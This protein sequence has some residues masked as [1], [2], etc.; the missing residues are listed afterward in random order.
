MNS[1][2]PSSSDHPIT[3]SPD[4]PTLADCHL[5]FE[6]SLPFSAVARLACRRGHPFA[7]REAFEKSRAAVADSTTFLDLYAEICRLFREPEDFLDASKALADSL[8][9]WGLAYAEVYVSPEIFER[10]GLD[11][12]V[13]LEA[14]C[15]GLS[16]ATPGGTVCRVLLDAVRQWGPES[17]GRVLDL[18]ERVRPLAV[19]GFGLGGD[20]TSQPASAF[21]GVYARAR[22]LGLKT[23]VHAGEWAGP[24]SLRGALD[25]LRPDRVDH[26]IAAASDRSLLERLAGERTF[27]CV[28][29][30]GNLIT[31]AVARWED[32]PLPRLLEAGVPVALSADDP[33][34]FA[35]DTSREYAVA[36]DRLGL[37]PA[38]LKSCAENAWRAAFCS[39]AEREAGLRRLAAGALFGEG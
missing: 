9:G 33:L 36:R 11:S 25:A 19:V 6:G 30:S 21:A 28:A 26:G 38:A 34:L 29:P 35:T 23:S 27:L 15:E 37:S 1:E 12:A 2:S 32:H 10:V 22:S 7:D 14:V 13:C 3:R 8:A 31:G 20:E 24:E 39:E 4:R 5:H 17:A 16:S 18:Y